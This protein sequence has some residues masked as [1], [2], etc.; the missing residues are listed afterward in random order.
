MTIL[1]LKVAQAPSHTLLCCVWRAARGRGTFIPGLCYPFA[2]H[3]VIS[4]KNNLK[5]RQ[6][7]LLNAH[8]AALS[9]PGPV[10]R[11]LPKYSPMCLGHN[12]RLSAKE[13]IQEFLK[14]VGKF[15]AGDVR[16][17]ECDAS[18]TISPEKHEEM[19]TAEVAREFW[20]SLALFWYF[21]A[22][23]V[24]PSQLPTTDSW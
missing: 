12:Q 17:M 24:A 13:E 8:A 22:A 18:V 7:R 15:T 10:S 16:L 20:A 23:F 5:R 2:A 1:T 4:A 11:M 21:L 6:R 19:A 14:R 9:L 3:S